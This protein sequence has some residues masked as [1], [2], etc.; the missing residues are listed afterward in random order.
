MYHKLGIPFGYAYETPSHA[1]VFHLMGFNG[2]L[3][4]SLFIYG[5]GSLG[6]YAQNPI[7]KKEV[8]LK[9]Y[10]NLV[11]LKSNTTQFNNFHGIQTQLFV[12][13]FELGKIVVSC[14]NPGL[15]EAH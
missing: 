15:R 5:T 9:C 3:F 10:W 1:K 14:F 7:Q 8:L 4:I 11:R 6:L 12:S 2:E 13:E